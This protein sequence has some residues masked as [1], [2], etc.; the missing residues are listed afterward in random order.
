MKTGSQLKLV[1]MQ[2]AADAA[3]TSTD[4]VRRVFDHWLFMFG[5]S[6]NRCKLGAT[7]RP[8]ISAALALYDEDQ[9]MAAIDGMAS[10]PLDDCRSDKMRDAMREIEWFMATEARI[11]RWALK[12]DALKFDLLREDTAE[13]VEHPTELV[14]PAAKA[15]AKA[16]LRDIAASRRGAANA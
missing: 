10:D 9:L 4:P 3:A 16:R 6:A 7:R 14:D 8:V 1:Q 15:A 5:R 2:T 12:G 13:V 11:E